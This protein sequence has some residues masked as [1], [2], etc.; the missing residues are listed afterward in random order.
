MSEKST[1]EFYRFI[2]DTGAEAFSLG[3]RL[4]NKLKEITGESKLWLRNNLSTMASQTIDTA[5]YSF[6]VWWGVVDL[7]TAIELGIVKMMFKIGIAAFDTPFVY[8][9][10]SWNNVG[11]DR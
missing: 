7:Q 1:D 11:G 9:A 10:R 6:V 4:F 8:W 3:Y 5:I 2:F